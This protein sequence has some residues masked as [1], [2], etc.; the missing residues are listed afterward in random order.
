MG[1]GFVQATACDLLSAIS[2]HTASRR[3]WYTSAMAR[4]EPRD[5]FDMDDLERELEKLRGFGGTVFVG[6]FA[7]G[8]IVAAVT[9]LIWLVAF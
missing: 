8:V 6:I 3:P 2:R 5:P 1:S 9:V 7:S 4:P